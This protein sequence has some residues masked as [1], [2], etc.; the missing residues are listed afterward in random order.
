[1]HIDRVDEDVAGLSMAVG[2]VDVFGISLE[3]FSR[4]AFVRCHVWRDGWLC[5]FLVGQQDGKG[6]Q[7][8]PGPDPGYF[9]DLLTLDIEAAPQL[10]QIYCFLA[11]CSVRDMDRKKAHRFIQWFESMIPELAAKYDRRYRM[12]VESRCDTE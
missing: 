2:F 3:R 7:V 11:G 8:A 4:V 9:N 6:G 1:M 10:Y 5:T 12:A